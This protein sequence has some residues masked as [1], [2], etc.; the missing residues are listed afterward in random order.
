LPTIRHG[1]TPR[2]AFVPGVLLALEKLSALP[3]GLTTGL[4]AVLRS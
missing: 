1:T 3:A 4:H 2:E